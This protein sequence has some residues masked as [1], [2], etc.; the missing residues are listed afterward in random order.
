MNIYLWNNRITTE[1]EVDRY[2]NRMVHEQRNRVIKYVLIGSVVS[3]LAVF[4]LVK[5]NTHQEKTVE[6]AKVTNTKQQSNP[7]TTA[8]YS[9]A[10]Q[11]TK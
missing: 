2:L 8:T 10:N 5:V 4:V 7:V 9:N 3:A 11:K 1:K 6:S